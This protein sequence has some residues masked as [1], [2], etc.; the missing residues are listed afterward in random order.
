MSAKKYARV[1]ITLPP[2]DLEAA[3]RLAIEQ[4]RSRSW[5]VA[6]ALRQYV[7]RADQLSSLGESRQAQVLRDLR[8]TAEARIRDAEEGAVQVVDADH[9]DSFEAPLRFETYEAFAEWRRMAAR[10]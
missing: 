7:A 10:S 2:G 8:L 4:D 5:I 6:E 1:A 3:D 9:G